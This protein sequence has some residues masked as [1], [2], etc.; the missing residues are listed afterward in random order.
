M[1]ITLR[2]GTTNSGNIFF[3]DSTSG[4]AQYAGFIQY[5]HAENKL[6]LGTNGE[7][8]VQVLSNGNLNISDGDLVIG[9]NGHGI[10]FS[11]TPSGIGGGTSTS[12]Q[13]LDEYEE[14][15]WTPIDDSGEGL[16]LTV[17]EAVY[18]RIGR[19]VIARAE[20]VTYPS[21]SNNS[22][23]RIGGLPFTVGAPFGSGGA[24]VSSSAYAQRVLANNGTT[25]M[26]VYAHETEGGSTNAN[27]SGHNIYGICVIYEAA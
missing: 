15:T 3:S 5:Y 10:D 19:L 25:Y 16:T 9:T 13:I 12:A 26:W 2:S 20:R 11:A 14:G 18:T 24:P 8:R 6:S 4:A 22:G 17:V 1:G 21:T 27:L 7:N 23:A